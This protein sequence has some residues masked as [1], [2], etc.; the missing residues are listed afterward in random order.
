MLKTFILKNGIRIATYSIPQTR[1]I[2]LSQSVKGGSIFDNERTSGL[3]HFMEHII[4][5]G[6]PSL[7]N[8]EAFSD[9]IESLAGHYN[10][11]TYITRVNF[12]LMP[13]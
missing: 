5:Q 4:C 7:P 10:A 8:V 11:T 1:S 13:L 3:A 2:Y 9:F 6:I 12:L